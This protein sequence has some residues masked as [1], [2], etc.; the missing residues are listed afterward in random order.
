MPDGE[1]KNVVVHRFVYES[2]VGPIPEGL[3]LDHLCRVRA[4]CNPAH[5]EPVTDRVNILRGASITAANARKTHCDHGHEFT[6]QNT[7][8]HRGRRLCRACNRD[9]VARYAAVRKGRT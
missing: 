4:C 1:R 7:Y 9:A 6:S 3:V 5:L 2:L 8:R